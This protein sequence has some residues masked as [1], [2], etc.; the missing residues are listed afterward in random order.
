MVGLHRPTADSLG[1][2]LISISAEQNCSVLNM[3]SFK[4]ANFILSI[5]INPAINELIPAVSR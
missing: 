5:A 3:M 1:F 4:A 2:L